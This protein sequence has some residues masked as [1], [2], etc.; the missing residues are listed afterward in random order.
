MPPKKRSKKEEVPTQVEVEE[1]E[2]IMDPKDTEAQNNDAASTSSKASYTPITDP[3]TTAEEEESEKD[4]ESESSGSSSSSEDETEGKVERAVR[5]AKAKFAIFEQLCEMQEKAKKRSKKSKKDK[6]DKGKKIPGKHQVKRSKAA[7][8]E[9]TTEKVAAEKPYVIPKLAK[10]KR[11]QD[12]L[13]PIDSEEEGGGESSSESNSS[14]SE[15]GDAL[16][17]MEKFLEI[18]NTSGPPVSDRLAKFVQ[19][20]YDKV[21]EP[22]EE[23]VQNEKHL[24]PK[25]V[26]SLEPPKIN[27]QLMGAV[28]KWGK[29]RDKSLRLAQ[30]FIGKTVIPSL[31]I[32][33]IIVDKTI[34]KKKIKRLVKPLVKELIWLQM[35]T[36]KRFSV[37]RKTL[38]EPDLGETFKPLYEPDFAKITTNLFGDD[39]DA[40]ITE[41]IA[42]N[43][44]VKKMRKERPSSKNWQGP[45]RRSGGQYNN[46]YNNNKGYSQKYKPQYKDQKYR[47][48]GYQ[49]QDRTGF[50][51]K[52]GKG[53]ANFKKE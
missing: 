35:N 48:N 52:K 4:S 2:P 11:T 51:G 13:D 12:V 41:L 7:K 45:Q 32:M 46:K 24:R 38:L 5:K 9:K 37:L 23:K 3:I 17:E 47:N 43:N 25:N 29:S 19:N 30:S 6:K 27:S 22:A 16:D 20:Y 39:V 21:I 31:K 34:N 44:L 1:E 50:K 10:K 26:P 53:K 33:D 8:P 15:D 42:S 18:D 49:H 40:R 14:D 36:F 28:P